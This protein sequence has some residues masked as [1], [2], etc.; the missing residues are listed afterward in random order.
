MI[1]LIIDTDIGADSDDAVALALACKLHKSG[2]VRLRAVTCSTTRKDAGRAVQAI[3]KFYGLADIPVGV[4]TAPVLKCDEIN[5]YNTY[6]AD[7]YSAAGE[8]VDA[9]CLIKS[10]LE[11]LPDGAIIAAIGPLS[12]IAELI[13]RDEALVDSR[14]IRLHVM[15]GNFSDNVAEWN[16]LQ[17]IKAA[18]TVFHQYKG[19]IIVTPFEL[20]E[21]VLTGATIPNGPVRDALNLFGKTDNAIRCSWDPITVLSCLDSGTLQV[22]AKGIVSVSDD[23]ITVLGLG[24]GE[25]HKVLSGSTEVLR[26]EIDDLISG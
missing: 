3:L 2:R 12:N 21:R 24:A 8:C 26:E 5:H 25:R 22:R 1:D 4:I 6:L 13:I 19:E 17:N 15:G 11:S 7:N 9:L 18:Q 14:V 16:I 20:G 23:G 10:V